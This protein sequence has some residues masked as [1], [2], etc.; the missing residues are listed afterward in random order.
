MNCALLECLASLTA[1]N[2]T[3]W[4]WCVVVHSASGL[5]NKC[6]QSPR[7]EAPEGA[8]PLLQRLNV[9][10]LPLYYFVVEPLFV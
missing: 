2:A 6:N 10:C 7:W 1:T 9:C 5:F 8:A 3:F 4:F